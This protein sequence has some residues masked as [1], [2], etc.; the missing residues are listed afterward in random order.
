M[1]TDFQKQ[2]FILLKN[3]NVEAKRNCNS[4]SKKGKNILTI[5]FCKVSKNEVLSLEV[6]RKQPCPRKMNLVYKIKM[7]VRGNGNQR[8]QV[9]GNSAQWSV[10][11]EE[12]RAFISLLFHVVSCGKDKK[13][14]LI[15]SP[16]CSDK[17][18]EGW[19][20]IQVQNRKEKGFCLRRHLREG[21]ESF[22]TQE[23]EMVLSQ[24]TGHSHGWEQAEGT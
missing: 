7:I 17:R 13:G 24:W 6:G 2:M 14:G 23:Q 12:F 5:S 18:G 1:T 9:S 3:S 19:F 20:E 4:Q 15:C 10:M 16:L 21:R 22:G 11:Y 8:N